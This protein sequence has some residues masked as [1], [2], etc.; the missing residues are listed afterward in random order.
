MESIVIFQL[1]QAYTQMAGKDLSRNTT[2][3]QT[4]LKKYFTAEVKVLSHTVPSVKHF[5]DILQVQNSPVSCVTQLGFG[6]V[7]QVLT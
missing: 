4:C 2:G 7:E 1:F 6:V 5:E 3:L